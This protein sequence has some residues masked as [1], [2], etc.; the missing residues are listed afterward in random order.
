[1][2][3]KPGFIDHQHRVLV[4]KMLS[5]IVAHQVALSV[6]AESEIRGCH[7]DQGSAH[8]ACAA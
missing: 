1:L 7:V 3:E 8:P 4:R 6:A 5:D 2:L